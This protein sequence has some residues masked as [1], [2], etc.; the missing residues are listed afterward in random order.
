MP[1]RSTPRCASRW[2]AY[3]ALRVNASIFSYVFDD[4]QVGMIEVSD[5]GQPTSF[6]GNAGEAERWGSELELQWSPTDNLLLAA[7]WAH[8]DGDFEEYPPQCGT[9]AFLNTCIDTDDIAQRSN[10]ADDQLSLVGDWVFAKTD[11]ADFMAHVEVFW[12]DE[13]AAAAMW[14]TTYDIPG[15]SYPY[16]HDH[17]ML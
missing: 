11:W 15:G 2:H 7:S 16:I 10:A 13:T 5:S 9:G 3:A 6:T 14:P 1:G 17:I 12:Q 8:M 4:M